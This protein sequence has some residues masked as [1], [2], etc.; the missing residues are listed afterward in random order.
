MASYR[1]ITTEIAA[2]TTAGT[3]STVSSADIVRAV[4]TGTA[5]YLV[6]VLDENDD[7]IGTMTMTGGDTAFIKKRETDK[8]YAGNANVRLT[9]TTFPVM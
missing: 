4:N 5:A 7:T 8:I 1:P 3:A 9:R 2:P 6:T